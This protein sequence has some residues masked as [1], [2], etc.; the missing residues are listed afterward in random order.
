VKRLWSARAWDEYLHWQAADPN[1]L[2]RLN[3][4]LEECRRNPFTGS[5]KPEPLKT[6]FRGWW[7]R[8][9]TLEHRLIYRVSAK[10]S[11]QTL[12]IVQCRFH[13]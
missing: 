6:E 8:R 7:S 11:D 12:E 2:K 1:I 10:G 4:L 3:G 13:Y 9:I 5:G